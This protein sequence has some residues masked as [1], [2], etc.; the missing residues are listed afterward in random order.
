MKG[1][2]Q[3]KMVSVRGANENRKE[4]WEKG[5]RRLGFEMLEEREKREKSR[6]TIRF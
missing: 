5:R 4:M 3:E 2:G 1:G 6:M